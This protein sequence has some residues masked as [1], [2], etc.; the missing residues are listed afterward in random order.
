MEVVVREVVR[1]GA[2]NEE[3]REVVRTIVES[4]WLGELRGAW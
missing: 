3:L 2:V 4:V 1:R